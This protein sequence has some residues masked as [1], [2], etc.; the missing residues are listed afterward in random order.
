MVQFK[1]SWI[2]QGADKELD[3]FAEET[4]RYIGDNGLTTSQIRNFYGEIKRIQSGTFDKNQASFYLLRPK[5]AYAAGRFPKNEGLKHFKDVIDNAWPCVKDNETYNN[6]C[7][8]V[9]AILAYHRFY[10]PKD[11]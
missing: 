2:T 9:E 10:H 3:Q 8:L 7:N 5:M 1:Q 6:F 11:N 4:G